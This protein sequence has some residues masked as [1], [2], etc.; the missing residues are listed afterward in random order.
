MLLAAHDERVGLEARVL[1]ERHADLLADAVLDEARAAVRAFDNGELVG[2]LHEL[3]DLGAHGLLDDVQQVGRVDL[4]VA[5]LGA[6]DVER[7]DATLV[8]RGHRDVLEDAFDLVVGEAVRAEPFARRRSDHL[9]RA[10]A[11]RHALRGDANHA[12]RAAVGCDRG[13]VER[14]D[15]LR[16]HSAHRRRL[17]LGIARLDGHFGAQRVL[18]LAHELGHAAREILGTEL[19]RAKNDLPDG[20]VD[21]LLE[22][23][24]VGA[25]LAGP[26]VDDALQPGR[27]QLLLTAVIEANHLFYARDAHAREG[28]V[29]GRRRGLDVGCGGPRGHA[30]T[31]ATGPLAARATMLVGRAVRNARPAKGLK[32]NAASVETGPQ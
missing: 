6:A 28:E 3:E 13:A 2:P 18:A 7:A 4:A 26:E 14:V 32:V 23:R 30:S 15:L 9:L 31:V 11:G 1:V 19:R 25:L 29:D 8:V 17:V 24:H 16:G 21:R 5:A 20:V 22:A 27:E 12:T 10:R